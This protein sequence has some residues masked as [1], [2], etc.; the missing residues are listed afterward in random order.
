M[1]EKLKDIRAFW[2]GFLNTIKYFI[3]KKTKIILLSN[4]IKRK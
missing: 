3:E 1:K 4:N 2:E